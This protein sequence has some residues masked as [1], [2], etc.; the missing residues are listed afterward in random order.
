[1]ITGILNKFKKTNKDD[2]S[3]NGTDAVI[4]TTSIIAKVKLFITGMITKKI[5]II[6]GCIAGVFLIFSNMVSSIQTII[7]PFT[8]ILA[9]ETV[10]KSYIDEYNSLQQ[11]FENRIQMVQQGFDDVKIDY[12]NGQGSNLQDIICIMSVEFNQ[13]LKFNPTERRRFNE[14]FVM[15]NS[16]STKTEIYYESIAQTEQYTVIQKDDE[17]NDIPITKTRIIH[18]PVQKKRIIIDVNILGLEDVIDRIGF[19]ADK[20]EWVRHLS[21]NDLSE[22]YPEIGIPSDNICPIEMQQRIRNAQQGNMTRKE[23]I[24]IAK[25][26]NG[27]VPYFWGGK[28]NAGF[29]PQWGKPTRVTSTGSRTTGTIRPF[30]LDC[31]GYVDWVYKTAGFGNILSDGT[32]GQWNNSYPIQPQEL[33]IG[34]LAFKQPPSSAGINHIG[35]YIGIGT[36]GERLFIHSASTT[37][38][39]INNYKGF[40]YWRRAYVKFKGD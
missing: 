37:G 31:S 14:L 30:G 25:S 20:K 2:I 8:Q 6:A 29:N 26:L 36:T 39:T 17:G 22:L 34:D 16:F 32:T 18:V 10:V 15:M 23:L 33:K 4:N 7:T 3:D 35:I 11:N 24:D 38:V 13:D 40:K 5:L 28:S 27:K 1:L 9:S 19:D 12:F 21:T